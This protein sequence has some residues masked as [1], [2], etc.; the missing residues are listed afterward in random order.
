MLYAYLPEIF[1]PD[2]PS[3]CN[4]YFLVKV[5]DADEVEFIEYIAKYVVTEL[6]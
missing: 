6:K 5:H 1:N 3:T 4:P 2:I